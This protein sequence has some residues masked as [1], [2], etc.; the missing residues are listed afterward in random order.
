MRRSVFVPVLTLSLPL[1]PLA[2][3]CGAR[4]GPEFRDAPRQDACTPVRIEEDGVDVLF[5]VDNSGS[6]REEQGFL[7]NEI[8][9]LIRTLATGDRDADGVSDFPAV[10]SLHVGV[11]TSDMGSGDEMNVRTCTP[12]LGDD[13]ILRRTV[14]TPGGDCMPTYPSGT[15]AF[16][17][18]QDTSA[19]S[20]VIGCVV[21]VG[22]E[23]CGFE[24]Q[25][26][27]GLKA[28]TPANPEVWTAE[29]YT[30]PRFVDGTTGQANRLP[31]HGSDANAGF[32]RPNS[33]FTLV[34][35]TDEEDCSVADYSIFGTDPRFSSV[36]SNLRC[37]E[38]GSDRAVVYPISRYVNGFV[39]L[40]RSPELLV[41]SAIV[42]IPP[43][44]ES[45]A[46]AHDFRTVL[47]HP[48][49]QPVVDETGFNVRA[50]CTTP[51][52]TAYPPVRIVETAAQLHAQGANVA[53]TSI[54]APSFAPAF[55]ALIN[56]VVVAI[57]ACY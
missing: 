34:L 55:D 50:A 12:G 38:F 29:G 7:I 2:A 16:M 42:G 36:P 20:S 52:G 14:R 18:G 31:G 51:N 37:N 39:G 30:P 9:R 56:R 24:Q 28:V 54:C 44:V 19:F 1:L 4:S 27:A 8:P 11:V 22:T 45:A 23:G 17:A 10:T 6:M 33:V 35:V 48:D 47:S 21:N 57:D 43:A 40:R 13:G 5:V 25:L 49:M 41:F 53:V 15:F 46:A 26:E 32:L 3:S